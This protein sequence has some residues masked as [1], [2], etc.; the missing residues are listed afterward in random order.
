MRAHH[1]E[2]RN[3]REWKQ[4]AADADYYRRHPIA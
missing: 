1:V 2:W 4:S 3:N